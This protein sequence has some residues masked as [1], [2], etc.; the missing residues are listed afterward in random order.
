[1]TLDH[2]IGIEKEG[3]RRTFNQSSTGQWM[4]FGVTILFGVIAWD[5]I[6]TGNQVSSI[7][8]GILGTVDLVALVTVFITSRSIQKPS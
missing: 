2:R 8:G 1:M 5:L 4:G 7:A 6:K 3:I